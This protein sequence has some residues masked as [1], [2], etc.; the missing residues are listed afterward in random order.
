MNFKQHSLVEVL[1]NPL[2]TSYQK[3][4]PFNDNLLMP[5]PIIDNPHA[6]VEMVEETGAHSTHDA[7]I[8]A[9]QLA[10][11]LDAYAASWGERAERL[12]AAESGKD[13]IMKVS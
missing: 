1:G 3:R 9:D 13:G 11:S 7:P 6:L 8:N 2:F 12:Q 4:Q 10:D 5:C